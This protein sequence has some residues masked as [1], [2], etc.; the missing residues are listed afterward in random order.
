[1]VKVKA[2]NINKEIGGNERCDR[3]RGR[4]KRKKGTG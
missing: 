1:M 2:V 3:G 4:S